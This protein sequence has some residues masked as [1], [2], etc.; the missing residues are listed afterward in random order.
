MNTETYIEDAR[1]HFE[2]AML[3]A[4]LRA[5]HE[6]R[7]A[8][9]P[10]QVDAAVVYELVHVGL[11]QSRLVDLGAPR[12]VNGRVEPERYGELV[13]AL[14]TLEPDAATGSF[15]A[16]QVRLVLAE[17]GA[18]FPES[19]NSIHKAVEEVRAPI[20]QIL[21]DIATLG[22]PRFRAADFAT[23]GAGGFDKLARQHFEAFRAEA[24]RQAEAAFASTPDHLKH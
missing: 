19:T 1:Y 20:R 13:E 10:D 11:R 17:V 7:V 16:D 18:I 8:I 2:V 3:T 5:I 6:E 14:A 15:E 9:W 12:V 24:D 22:A 21:K 23:L 4:T